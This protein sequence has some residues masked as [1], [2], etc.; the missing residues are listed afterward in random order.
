MSR[1]PRAALI[2]TILAVAVPL[3]ACGGS[4]TSTAADSGATGAGPGGTPTQGGTIYYAHDLEVPCLPG[5]WVEE[6]YI[7]RQYADSLVSQV[8]SGK[9]VPWLA[10]SWSVS[11]DQLTWTFHLKPGVKFSDGTPLN[12]QAV[13]DNFNW[14]LNPKA[15]NSTV[16]AIHRRLLPVG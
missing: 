11:S 10:T 3:S 13:V 1:T 2:L 7:E 8:S 6:A 4:S 5:R 15:G 12:A 14:W 16:A 9:I